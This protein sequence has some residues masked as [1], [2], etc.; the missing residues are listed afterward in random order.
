V[1]ISSD[2][3]TDSTKFDGD[4]DSELDPDVDM[5][6]EDE[7]DTPDSV[8][9]YGDV[10][11]ERDGEDDE[12]EDEPEEDEEMEDEEEVEEEDEDEAEDKDEDD[13]KEPQTIGQG[14]S[15]NTSADD[16]DTMVDDQQIL[17]PE[18]GQ[19]VGEHTQW[20]QLPAHAPGQRTPD[21]RPRPYTQG[22]HPLGGL[23]HLGLATP[24]E[25][26]PQM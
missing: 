15:V 17:L 10:C 19:K 13:G 16:V 25:T 20:P 11:K 24:H 4:Y 22:N 21:P 14:E 12:D 18:Q 6:T 7:V 9:L 2:D 5:G 26:S 3:D 23:E 1:S 8:D